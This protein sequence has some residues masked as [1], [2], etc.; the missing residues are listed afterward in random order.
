MLLR[1]RRR[2]LNYLDCRLAP[3]TFTIVSSISTS[4]PRKRQ[5]EPRAVQ[6]A[7]IHWCQTHVTII[8]TQVALH[9]LTPEDVGYIVMYHSLRG[10]GQYAMV[11][12]LA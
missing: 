3:C 4:G 5:T 12:S 1:T 8:V 7:Q 2:H 9:T 11:E 6:R 10:L